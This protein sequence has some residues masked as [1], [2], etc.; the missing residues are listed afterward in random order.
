LEDQ[1]DEG[2][3]ALQIYTWIGNFVR[4]VVSSTNDENSGTVPKFFFDT[5]TRIG[6]PEG[7]LI[8]VVC[9]VDS[10]V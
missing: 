9:L 3:V 10:A 1:R 4:E 6:I 7:S 8:S 2:L 5:G